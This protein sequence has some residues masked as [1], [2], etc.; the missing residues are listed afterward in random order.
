MTLILQTQY[1]IFSSLAAIV[2]I[3]Q[4]YY[5]IICRNMCKDEHDSGGSLEQNSSTV[6]SVFD[7]YCYGCDGT[8]S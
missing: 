4:V 5:V 8:D 1:G 7:L 2:W 6:T 3:I